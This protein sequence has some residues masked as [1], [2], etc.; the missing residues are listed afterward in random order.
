MNFWVVRVPKEFHSIN[1]PPN[2]GSCKFGS[3]GKF[4]GELLTILALILVFSSFPEVV[5]AEFDELSIVSSVYCCSSSTVEFKLQS[6][7]L[8]LSFVWIHPLALGALFVCFSIIRIVS[9]IL[10]ETSVDSSISFCMSITSQ[11]FKISSSSSLNT[12]INYRFELFRYTFASFDLC[13]LRCFVHTPR[14]PPRLAQSLSSFSFAL[15]WKILPHT[16][17]AM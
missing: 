11:M 3:F 2:F 15:S 17:V 8:T 13:V 7:T 10:S 16:L 4:A 6:T 5:V 12:L 1:R 14:C 9:K